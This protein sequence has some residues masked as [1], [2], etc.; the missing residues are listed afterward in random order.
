MYKGWLL[1]I[2]NVNST[3]V[4]LLTSSAVGINQQFPIKTKTV[5]SS[6]IQ[7]L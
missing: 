7:F 1:K 3:I 4:I 2:I 5:I 6:K